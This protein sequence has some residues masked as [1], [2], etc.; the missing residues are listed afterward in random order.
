MLLPQKDPF[1]SESDKRQ[2]LFAV[3]VSLGEN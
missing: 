1:R 3:Q 2:K